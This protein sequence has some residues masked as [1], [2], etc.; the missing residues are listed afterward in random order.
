VRTGRALSGRSSDWGAVAGL[1]SVSLLGWP[2]HATFL[3]Q[4]RTATAEL[5]APWYYN[6]S[7]MVLL[8]NRALLAEP[9]ADLFYSA[10]GWGIRLAVVA[11]ATCMLL[12]S[13][14]ARLD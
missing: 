7:P 13:L 12:R 10:L 8:G 6:S 9:G 14:A 4:L 5:G 1:A 11:F 2:I 3:D